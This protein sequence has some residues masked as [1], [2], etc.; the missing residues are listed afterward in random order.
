MLCTGEWVLKMRSMLFQSALGGIFLFLFCVFAVLINS[1]SVYSDHPKG[2]YLCWNNLN[3]NL[4]CARADQSSVVGVTQ[5]S[6]IYCGGDSGCSY[7]LRSVGYCS[8]NDDGDCVDGWY[9]DNNDNKCAILS[10]MRKDSRGSSFNACQASSDPQSSYCEY[11]CAT[12]GSYVPTVSCNQCRVDTDCGYPHY[13][14]RCISGSCTG[15][16]HVCTDNTF[17]SNCVVGEA[18]HVC[19]RSDVFLLDCVEGE[20]VNGAGDP[21]VD[22]GYLSFCTSR[23]VGVGTDAC[24]CLDSNDCV[25]GF[26]CQQVD[27]DIENIKARVCVETAD[28]CADCPS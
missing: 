12:R 14:L 22:C 13:E 11:G 6:C 19:T 8:C 16:S 23:P 7:D 17:G 15:A 1:E 27:T 28:P 2:H 26:S 24:F 4:F 20:I 10:Y 3:I 18:V 21:C 9:C 25:D 5:T